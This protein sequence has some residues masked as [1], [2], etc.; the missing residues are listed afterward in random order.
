MIPLPL[1]GRDT[2]CFPVP[3]AGAGRI[4]EGFPPVEFTVWTSRCTS[5]SGG[6][7]PRPPGH[8]EPDDDNMRHVP[9]GRA[10]GAR[11]FP[12]A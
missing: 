2:E 1:F 12:A 9:N 5:L 3:V 11:L 6:G 10:G 7:A 8:V 4:A